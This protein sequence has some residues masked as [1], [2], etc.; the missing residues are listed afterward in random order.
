MIKRGEEYVTTLGEGQWTPAP[1]LNVI[2][3]DKSFGFQVSETG[4]GFTWSVNSRENRLTPWSNDAVSD[5]PGEIIYL[6]DEETGAIWTPTPLP[7]RETGPYTI[8]HGHG[9]TI[10][11]HMSQGIEQELRLFVP[12]DAPVKISLLRLRNRTQNRRKLSVTNYNELVLGFDRSRTVPYIVTEADAANRCIRVRNRYNNEFAGRMAFFATNHAVTSLTC[13]RKEFL[14]RNGNLRK[15][16]AL[17]R[18]RLS[19]RAGAG[20]DPCA[21]LQTTVELLPDEEVE[22]IFLTG[23]V[24]SNAEVDNVISRFRDLSA[25]KESFTQVVDYWDKMLGTIEVRTPDEA[26]NTI[27]NRWLLYQTLACRVWARSAFYQSGGAF[28]FRDQLQDVMSLVYTSRK[29]RASKF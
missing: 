4:S 5:P 14:G 15:P 24:E 11:E 25:V 10:F 2:A 9:Y 26:L 29:L 20:L 16:A 28:G 1:W 19:G 21:V 27:V 13:D 18:E 22:I 23:E 3:N 8:R 12:L 6:R 17:G 7:I